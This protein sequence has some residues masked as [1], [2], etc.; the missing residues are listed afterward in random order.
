MLMTVGSQLGVA[1]ANFHLY[2][3]VLRAKVQWERTFDA[4]SIRLPCSTAG[5]GR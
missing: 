3:R 1:I 4:I 2:E 5:P